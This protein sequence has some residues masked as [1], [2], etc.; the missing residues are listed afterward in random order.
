MSSRLSTFLRASVFDF[1]LVLIISY[2]LVSTV[3]FGFNV[4]P[5]LRVNI[6]LIAGALVALLVVLFAGSWSKRAVLLSALGTLVVAAVIIVWG[7]MSSTSENFL[8]DIVQNNTAFAF[9]LVLVPV[10]SYLLTRRVA[11]LAIF[12]V[13]GLVT[14]G[15]IKILYPEYL[16]T[17]LMV[18][19]IGTLTL[20]IYKNYQRGIYSAKSVGKVVFGQVFGSALAMSAVFVG[21]GAL[22]WFLILALLSPGAL[23]PPK[24]F[25]ER[26]ALETVYYT[27]V[28][29]DT[30]QPNEENTSDETNDDERKTD[31][32]T[33]DGT[34]PENSVGSSLEGPADT[35]MAGTF[36]YALN[37]LVEQFNRIS[38]ERFQFT[39]LIIALLA[40]VALVGVILLKRHLRK[41]RLKRLARFSYGYQICVLYQFLLGRLRRLGFKKPHP[42]TPLEFA[43]D[44]RHGMLIFARGSDEVDFVRVTELYGAAF[45]GRQ[46]MTFMELN[47]V[48]KY[49]LAFF[50][51]ARRYTGTLKWLWKFWRI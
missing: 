22:V 31:K 41:W 20:F 10:V 46:D 25:Q 33:E 29:D 38:Y 42:V 8:E 5:G 30:E 36:S 44:T 23:D 50:R 48:T 1:V 18:F 49:Y 9:I 2:A 43:R 26:R 37:A 12:A 17:E 32:N 13:A 34:S 40:L 24:L 51:N 28:Y 7:V 6:G 11:G 27:G 21:A 35:S 3:S 15:L 14:C 16:F 39:G 19:L 45:Y 47:E 4:A